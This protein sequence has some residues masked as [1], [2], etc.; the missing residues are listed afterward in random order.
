MFLSVCRQLRRPI[1]CAFAAAA[2]SILAADH[3]RAAE[4]RSADDIAKPSQ[5]NQ[6]ELHRLKNDDLLK[7]A[8]E[9][10]EK[11]ADDYRAAARALAAA[12]VLFEEATKELAARVETKTPATVQLDSERN[13]PTADDKA[14]AAVEES[15]AK[16]AAAGEMVAFV[17]ARQELLNRVSTRLDDCQSAADSFLHALTELKPFMIEIGL[18]VNDGSLPADKIPLDLTPNTLEK[19]RKD[20]A[21]DQVKRTQKAAEAPKI[22][23]AV[24]EQLD[25]AKTRVLAADGEVTQAARALAQEQR[26]ME[27]EKAYARRSPAGMMVDLTRLVEEGDGLRGSHELAL[28]RFYTASAEVEKL[29]KTLDALKQPEVIIPQITRAE[30]VEVAA[31]SIQELINFYSAQVQAVEGL[32]TALTA[33][34]K[35][36]EEF[37]ADA[38]VSHDHLF[39][40]NVI[41]E[42]LRKAG[43]SED[44]FPDG[45]QPK[46]LAPVVDRVTKIGVEVHTAIEQAK[47]EFAVLGTQLAEA[48]HA[49]DDATKQLSNLK[50]SQAVTT[51]ALTWEEQFKGM[52]ADQ[53][54]ENFTT[55]RQDLAEKLRKLASEEA[56]YKD[57]AATVTDARAKLDELKD[58]LLRRAEEQKHADRTRIASELR[59]EAGLDRT[60]DDAS[61][62]PT[63]PEG[64]KKSEHETVTEPDKR[65]EF[66]KITDSLAEFQHILAARIRVLDEREDKTK[67]LL[68][69]L[70]ALDTNAA[71]YNGSL[72]EARELALQ[73]NAAAVE[74]KKRVGKGEL[75]RDRIPDGVIDAIRVE[76]RTKL[77]ADTAVVLAALG[78][79]A[80]EKEQL[81]RPDSD[82]EALK[83]AA[84]ELLH[85]VG[86]RLDVIVTLKKLT[87]EYQREKGA[88]SPSEVKRLDQI[89]AD[90]RAADATV[91]ERLL[92]IDPSH[93]AKNLEELLEAY[94]QELIEI[95][96]KDENLKKQ[97]DKV[98]QLI[99][100]TR[101]ESEAVARALPLL[102]KHAA[103]LQ[104]AQ[105][106]DLVLAR[107][108]LNPDRADELLQAFHAKTGRLLPK[109]VPALNVEKAE[110][111]NEIAGVLFQRLVQQEAAERW[112]EILAARLAPAGIKAEAGTYQDVLAGV[113][114]TTGANARRIA[115]LTGVEPPEPG[116]APAASDA[117]RPVGGEIGNTRRELRGAR[118]QG[119]RSIGIK[120]A[121]II[122]VALVLP[123]LVLWPL[124]KAL[125]GDT[126]L[127]LSALTTFLKTG[128]W[129]IA[130]AFVLS[131]LGFDVTAIVAGF[132]IGGLAIGLAAQPMIADVIAAVVIFA[133]RK[134]KIGEVIKLGRNEPAK[135]VGLAWRS[136]QLQNTV[137]L[138]IH[139]PN[140]QVTEEPVQNLTK[141]GK[142][143]DVLDVTVTTQREVSN[144]LAVIRQALE[145]CKHV[146]A[147]HGVAVK[148][149]TQK[150]ETKVVKYQF[151]WF[152][153]EYEGR[154]KT[155]DEVFA[156]ISRSLGE[157]NLKETEVTLA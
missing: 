59:E 86:Q 3:S 11:A 63:E 91:S 2:V 100:F 43:V 62:A 79:V 105:E 72:A 49:R 41:A 106:E 65:S 137:G 103:R 90:R 93:K 143:F 4:P 149:F 123:H 116:A 66:E 28:A 117:R 92:G 68:A 57:F 39:K 122:I 141:E 124:R 97:R 101:S 14:Q 53:L 17:Q 18:R 110:Q 36:G 75:S 6:P 154:D 60:D 22:K 7:Q 83:G 8:G 150:G 37:E 155:R 40:M 127:V 81:R 70:D 136:T 135:V 9:I 64:D 156:R 132:G 16:Q 134:F 25:E 20:V 146:T 152:V 98:D 99:E 76:L 71:A 138:V 147:D 46:R 80:E 133:E 15:K 61:A 111:V 129:M 88:R 89:A 24:A 13:A 67:S 48:Q 23:A 107:A 109:P 142:I 30:D 121:A 96:E 26:R 118:I 112:R 78:L 131:V 47:T 52:S 102:D 82:F 144:V 145:E 148:E 42:L 55:I 19:K 95:E 38:A 44:K 139:I 35:V 56:V 50:D 34:T 29:R 74:L 130:F 33:L 120:I 5:A 104:A 114:A 85:L 94:Y 157:E 21:A 115:A 77:D 126:G 69:A 1:W 31:K 84:R 140:R 128:V 51:A 45:G 54:V 125:G 12:E 113:N 151:W 153:E 27:M 87:T 73:L 58:L 32:Q 119:V 10:Y 108:R